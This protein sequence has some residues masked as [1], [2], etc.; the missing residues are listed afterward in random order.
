MDVVVN[1]I[2]EFRVFLCRVRIVEAEVCL[3]AKFFCRTEIQ[4]DAFCVS[5]VDV[6]VRLGRKTGEDM[7]ALAAFEIACDDVLDEVGRFRNVHDFL[8]EDFTKNLEKLRLKIYIGGHDLR[9]FEPFYG[10]NCPE[11]FP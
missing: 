6:A 9:M 7:I 2:D 11:S 5:D 10:Q 4:A 3:A 1:R 8:R